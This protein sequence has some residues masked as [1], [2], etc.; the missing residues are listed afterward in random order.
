MIS[1]GDG[2]QIG[3]DSQGSGPLLV[4]THGW[5]NDRTV[6]NP[7]IQNLSTDHMA[8][9]WDLRGH[10][11][12]GT[13][14]PGSYSREHALSDLRAVLNA[15]GR[16]AVLVGHSLGGYLSLA[17]ALDCPEDIAGLVLIAAGPGFRNAEARE[18]WNDAVRTSA[19][20]LDQGP[21]VE[22]ISMHVDSEVIDH[23]TD[24]SA[25]T[26]VILGER[27]KRFAAAASLFSRDLNVHESVVIPDQGHMVHLKASDQCADAIRSFVASLS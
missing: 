26:L 11:E 5:V 21:G 24:I 10:G 3:L 7:L 16:P 4:F 9:S 20:K 13:P 6:W 19:E 27:D 2:I 15:V 22:E 25:S 17:H 14:P 1:G 12:S 23:L 8:V 18:E